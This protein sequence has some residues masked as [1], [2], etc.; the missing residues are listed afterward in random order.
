MLNKQQREALHAKYGGKCAYCGCELSNKWHADHIV[1]VIRD[2]ERVKKGQYWTKRSKN[3]HNNPHLEIMENL[4][5]AC[6]QCNIHKS[7]LSLESFRRILS[8]KLE[9]L[10]RY[11]KDY[12]F[13]VTFG[14]IQPTPKPIIFY[15]EKVANNE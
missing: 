14:L 7:S 10:E 4:N 9:R 11:S 13:A 8:E 5:P 3:T 15:F 12:R 1:P 2:L 6:I